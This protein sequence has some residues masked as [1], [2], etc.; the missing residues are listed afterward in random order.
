M[1]IWSLIGSSRYWAL[2]CVIAFMAGAGLGWYEKSLRVPAL[3]EAQKKVDTEQ[4]NAEKEITRNANEQLK[5]DRNRIANDLARYK[6]LHP[7]SCII[8]AIPD[9]VR[10]GRAEHARG[11]GAVVGT[12][13]DF[14]DYAARCEGYRSEVVACIKFL[15]AER[16]KGEK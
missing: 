11:N 15:A 3:L 14:R 5:N 16:G 4:C 13:D 10:G 6:R 8:P 2:A 12:S 9:D 1:S 7:M